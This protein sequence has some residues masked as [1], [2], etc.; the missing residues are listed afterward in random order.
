MKSRFYIKIAAVTLLAMSVLSAR[1]QVYIRIHRA[2]QDILEYPIESI[3][4]I[5]FGASSSQGGTGTL[6]TVPPN[7]EIWYTST[8]G[9]IVIPH[10]VSTFGAK[11]V[12]IT[13]NDGKGVIKFDGDVTNV[14]DDTTIGSDLGAFSGNSTLESII[15]PQSVRHVSSYAFWSCF[16]LKN[17]QLPDSLEYLGEIIFGGSD[18]KELYIPV[19]RYLVANLCYSDSLQRYTGPY[20]STDGISLIQGTKLVSI[21]RAGVRSYVIP[22]GV[23]ELGTRAFYYLQLDSIIIPSSVTKIGT[24]T[25]FGN[26]SLKRLVV[27]ENVESIENFAFA[28]CNNLEYIV[29]K[30]TT[31]PVMLTNNLDRTNNCPIYVPS[32]SVA[33]YK[34]APNWNVY[35]DRIMAI[36]QDTADVHE[37][38]DL[39]LSVMWA[40]CNVGADSPEEGGDRFAWGETETKTTYNYMTSKWYDYESERFLKYNLYQDLGVADM[41]YMLDPEDDAAHVNWGDSWRTPS[42]QETVELKN[43]CNWVWTELNGT[44]GYMVTSKINGNSIFLPSGSYGSPAGANYLTNSLNTHTDGMPPYAL[45]INSSGYIETSTGG[46]YDGCYVRPVY[47]SEFKNNVL[48]ITGL[49]LDKQN[50]TVNIG[51]EADIIASLQGASVYDY[52]PKWYTDDPEI[53]VVSSSYSG[54][55]LGISEGQCVITASIGPYTQQCTVTVSK[56]DDIKEYV[57]LGLSVKWAT[58]NIGASQPEYHGAMFAW[59]ETESKT[60]YD[61]DNYRW[62]VSTFIS[63]TKY[64]TDSNYGN[65]GFVDDITEL[66][67]EDDVA[68]A[69]WGG[70]WRMPTSKEFEELI[71]SCTWEQTRQNGIY[72]YK[73]TSKVQGYTDNYIFL[74]ITGYCTGDRYQSYYYSYWSSSLDESEPYMSKRLYLGSGTPII[75]SSDREY[76]ITVRPVY[77]ENI[78]PSGPPVDEIWYSTTDGNP[79]DPAHTDVFGATLL[80]NTYQD[81]K[82]VMKFDTSVLEIGRY[83]FNGCSKLASIIIPSGVTSIGWCAFRECTRLSSITIPE[84][85]TELSVGVF[86]NCSSLTSVTIPDSVKLLNNQAFENCTRLSEINFSED[87]TYIGHWTFEGTAITSIKIPATV[88]D[89]NW[90][91]IAGCNNLTSV[92]VDASNPW[93]DSR[94]NCNAIIETATNTLI[95]G[96]ANT[97]I[98]RDV[99]ALYDY[100]FY[101][102]DRLKTITIP[103]GVETIGRQ[104]FQSC[105]SLKTL[106]V[107]STVTDI[108]LGAFGYCPQMTSIVFLSTTPPTAGDGILDYSNN[109]PIYVPAESLQ[110]Y[111]SAENWSVYADRIQAIP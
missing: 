38:V 7:D 5:S 76:G 99:T 105:D 11:I 49:S 51:Q 102:C 82:G 54:T 4:S 71:D 43:N 24:Q 108:G 84:S 19:C 9:G 32:E 45:Q 101:C 107:P 46:R 61:W 97:I 55:V 104:A 93:Y 40:T 92:S 3:D 66:E 12:S 44:T 42:P 91:S 95:S 94:E 69:V 88:S 72:G 110:E 64:C 36:P 90:G 27:P 74:P 75:A 81:G 26:D 18:V 21:A 103:E 63:Q 70:S 111:K 87:I 14:G 52:A 77:D 62:A 20:A 48:S 73:V 25:F 34:A 109:C 1:S 2:G 16:G 10:N 65:Q 15:L 100:S 50:V 23:T 41:K 85:V 89:I 28:D 68:H 86:M 17:V 22:D 30:P 60:S 57:D 31:P 79:M 37:Y 80:S 58:C 96:C 47:S 29:F 8:D 67:L 33:A 78:I 98:P 6:P 83:A 13:Y 53:A 35:A 39:G 106:I 56:V 59:G